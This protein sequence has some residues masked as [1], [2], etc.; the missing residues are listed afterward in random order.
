MTAG[1]KMELDGLLRGAKT[2]LRQS[3]IR[4]VQ[5]RRRESDRWVPTRLACRIELAFNDVR[6]SG[7]GEYVEPY[8]SVV[9]ICPTPRRSRNNA[10]V[11]LG[12]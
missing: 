4:V 8:L 5:R 10:M 6:R 3:R 9:G 1:G 2:N 7:N 12:L 11:L